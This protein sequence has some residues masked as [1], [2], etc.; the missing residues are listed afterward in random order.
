MS[1][2]NIDLASAQAFAALKLPGAEVSSKFGNASFSIG[3]KVFAFT[4]PDGLVLKL[5]ADE[6]LRVMKRRHASPLTMGRRTMREW[7]HLHL[8]H[9]DAYR[10][11]LPLLRSAMQYAR[12]VK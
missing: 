8:P 1:S 3:G 12:E 7:V 9:A 6:L 4:R 2:T 11:E 10:D 5:D